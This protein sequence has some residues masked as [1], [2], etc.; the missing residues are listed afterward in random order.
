M[1]E[2]CVQF[3]S[4]HKW[5]ELLCYSLFREGCQPQATGYSVGWCWT[6][7]VNAV[8]R[9]N[10]ISSVFSLP[11]FAAEL[12]HPQGTWLLELKCIRRETWY[13]L[14]KRDVDKLKSPEESS[15]VGKNITYEKSLKRMELFSIKKQRLESLHKLKVASSKK[16]LYCSLHLL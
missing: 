10:S 9:H 3:L 12:P 13:V 5:D 16:V 7:F 6:Y 4:P 14:F 2:I 8:G 11:C 15:E 1:W